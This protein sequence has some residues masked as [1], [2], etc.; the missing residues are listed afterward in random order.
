MMLTSL[1]EIRK[2]EREWWKGGVK[3][4]RSMGR[5]SGTHLNFRDSRLFDTQS[6][7]IQDPRDVM[8]GHRLKM[9]VKG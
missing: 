4:C 9:L 7:A 8:F 6:S 3:S 2:E 1:S 5:L